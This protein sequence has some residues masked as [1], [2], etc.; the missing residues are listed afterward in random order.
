MFNS[1]LNVNQREYSLVCL[2]SYQEALETMLFK[3]VACW[4]SIWS[5]CNTNAILFVSTSHTTIQICI[6]WQTQQVLAPWV[7]YMQEHSPSKRPIIRERTRCSLCTLSSTL[8]CPFTILFPTCNT[9]AGVARE[10]R[11]RKR[12]RRLNRHLFSQTG[13]TNA[14]THIHTT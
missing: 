5:T 12:S 1:H 10:E 6:Y 8:A 11:E 13:D 14:S 3:K 2:P 7:W 4:T 9:S